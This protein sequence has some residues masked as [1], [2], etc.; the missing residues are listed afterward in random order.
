MAEIKCSFVSSEKWLKTGTRAGLTFSPGWKLRPTGD[1][2]S[3]PFP[4]Q[5]AEENREGTAGELKVCDPQVP[6]PHCP[7]LRA[8]VCQLPQQNL[9]PH[10]G[11]A[12][13][14]NRCGPHEPC[15]TTGR[16]CPSPLPAPL[17][18]DGKCPCLHLHLAL[19]LQ[20]TI[21]S[22]GLTKN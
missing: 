1:M 15:V 20:P 2:I 3:T 22:K 19:I 21:P 9:L 16:L 4:L 11:R 7:G 8:Q 12:A 5:W 14:V 18:L 6:P 17:F 10:C 13:K